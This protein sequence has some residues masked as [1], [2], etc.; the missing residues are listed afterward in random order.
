MGMGKAAG[1]GDK[2]QA[3]NWRKSG[4][5]GPSGA[6]RNWGPPIHESSLS[7][8]DTSGTGLRVYLTTRRLPGSFLTRALFFLPAEPRTRT[9]GRPSCDVLP[10]VGGVTSVESVESTCRHI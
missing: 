2:A 9:F 6:W 5:D 1:G 7:L 10:L 4:P 3:N 8:V